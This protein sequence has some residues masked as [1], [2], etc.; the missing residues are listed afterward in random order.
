M[1]SDL[2][3]ILKKLLLSKSWCQKPIYQYK[4]KCFQLRTEEKKKSW[5]REANM[6]FRIQKFMHQV[7]IQYTLRDCSNKHCVTILKNC[8]KTLP[9][10]S[11]VI[12]VERILLVNP[13]V[14]L[15]PQGVPKKEPKIVW[16][17]GSGSRLLRF[18]GCSSLP[19]HGQLI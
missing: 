11:K 14:T 9:D 19:V 12:I 1:L 18:E 4:G 10:Y 6:I 15:E 13:T 5:C 8:Y 3:L 2:T 16:G 7:T 17:N